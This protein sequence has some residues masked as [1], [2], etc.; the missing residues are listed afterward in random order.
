VT[1]PVTERAVEAAPVRR[2][3]RGLR[4]RLG[5]SLSAGA[6]VLAYHEVVGAD[7]A[8]WQR[9]YSRV[10]TSAANFRAGLE[11]LLRKLEPARLE[12]LPALL[13]GG[14]PTPP[15]LVVTFD[16]GYAGLAREAADV[17]AELGLQP[18]LFVNAEFA[19]G[20]SVYYRVLLAL[21]EREGRAGE[22]AAILNER[23]G[24]DSF[25]AENL[26]SATKDWPAPQ[27]LVEPA[28]IALEGPAPRVHLDYDDLRGLVAR[29][30]T[31]ANHTRTHRPLVFVAPDELDDEILGN[32]RELRDAGLE[33]L[34]WLAYPNGRAKDVSAAVA[35]WLARHPQFHG[36]FAAGG[37]N[38][39]ATRTEWL[40]IPVLDEDPDALERLLR[41]AEEISHAV[42]E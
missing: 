11:R 27:D 40:R 35:D 26:A 25:T 15:R 9:A 14:P 13:A 29:G 33:P 21:L 38:L 17:C 39:R 16:D 37:V 18:T 32:E 20:R 10:T 36:V 1:W 42:H 5:G 19:S 34:P 6:Y 8:D 2:S 22:A 24:T 41:R 4:R 12:E 30:W 23:L 7:R 31:I 28:L 3:L